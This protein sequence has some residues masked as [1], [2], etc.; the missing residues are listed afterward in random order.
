MGNCIHSEQTILEND[1]ENL[2]IK[3][4]YVFANLLS[5]PDY[6]K[7]MQNIMLEMNLSDVWNR[8]HAI[9][10]TSNNI[11]NGMVMNNVNKSLIYEM[12]RLRLLRAKIRVIINH[13]YKTHI[14]V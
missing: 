8:Y 4:E 14:Q 1:I 12:K 10:R 13:P 3:F 6:M 7:E 2:A 5:Y 11:N 9:A